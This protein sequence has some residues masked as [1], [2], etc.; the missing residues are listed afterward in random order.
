MKHLIPIVLLLCAS[1]AATQKALTSMAGA[2]TP[3]EM[4][5]AIE[6]AVAAVQT[7]VEDLRGGFTGGGAAGDTGAG[8]G[9]LGLAA[10]LLRKK[11]FKA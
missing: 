3:A 11:L 7:D 1:C 10:W 4:T 9:A 6:E 2:A 8:V 5:V